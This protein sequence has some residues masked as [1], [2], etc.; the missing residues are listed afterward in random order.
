LLQDDAMTVANTPPPS[1]PG[2]GNLGAVTQA[3]YNNAG[4]VSDP[5]QA[6][7]AISASQWS[8]Y[9]QHFVPMENQMIQYAM[10]PNLAAK[11]M[12]AAQGMQ[13][14][15]NQQS[16]GIQ[17]RQLEQYDT[18]L[19]PEQKAAADKTKGITDATS[20]VTAANKAKDATVANQMGI[21]GAPMTG[22]TGAI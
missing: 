15:A 5:S 2:I 10:D 12:Q 7:G 20:N 17:T 6:L 16:T 3:S 21:M 8:T 4:Q 14:Q 11:N 1:L 19:T 22:V 9:L 13:Q 18:S